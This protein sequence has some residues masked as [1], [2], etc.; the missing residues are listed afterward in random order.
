MTALERCA[1]TR[2]AAVQVSA[3]LPRVDSA[4]LLEQRDWNAL[5]RGAGGSSQTLLC[6][7][8]AGYLLHADPRQTL[9]SQVRVVS[10]AAS[11]LSRLGSVGVVH[12]PAA[13]GCSAGRLTSG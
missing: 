9:G 12:G 8:L 7:G 2:V 1:V 5:C 6:S 13:K 11:L 4:L 3:V 10:A